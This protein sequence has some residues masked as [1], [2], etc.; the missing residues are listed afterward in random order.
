[1]TGDGGPNCQTTTE[2]IES[3]LSFMEPPFPVND[4]APKPY[5]LDKVI[6]WIFA[7]MGGLGLLCFSQSLAMKSIPH[8]VHRT[9]NG[10]LQTP[11]NAPVRRIAIAPFL[12]VASPFREEEKTILLFICILLAF[13]TL[14][15]YGGIQMIKSRRVGLYVVMLTALVSMPPYVSPICCAYCVLRLTGKLGPRLLG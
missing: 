4:E 11:A 15:L 1:M 2:E 8:A 13:S 12:S 5:N 3:I 6:G 7:V 10:V 9:V 14:N